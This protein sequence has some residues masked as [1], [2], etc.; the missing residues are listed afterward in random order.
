MSVNGPCVAYRLPET[1]LADL[2]AYRYRPGWI[3][4]EPEERTNEQASGDEKKW[5]I[6]IFGLLHNHSE[7]DG[8]E[9]ASQLT[10]KVHG[11]RYR[12]GVALADVD[13]YGEGNR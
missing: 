8:N 5:I 13:A 7:Q 10:G 1:S 3:Y 9:E 6:E 11:A 2:L 12:P 4:L